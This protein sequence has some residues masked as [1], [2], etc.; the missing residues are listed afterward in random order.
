MGFKS[1]TAGDRK[2]DVDR[3]GGQKADKPGKYRVQV[4]SVKVTRARRNRL[5][6]WFSR[7]RAR[8]AIDLLSGL[9]CSI[10]CTFPQ[11]S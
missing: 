9:S 2:E 5:S 1:T 10:A 7:S 11:T 6:C 3:G 4:T 8:G